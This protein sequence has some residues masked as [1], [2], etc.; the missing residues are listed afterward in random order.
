MLCLEE[1]QIGALMGPHP[2]RKLLSGFF[3]LFIEGHQ[4]SQEYPQWQMQ[5]CTCC[6]AK[7]SGN[8]R[9]MWCLSHRLKHCHFFGSGGGGGGKRRAALHIWLPKE[10]HRQLHQHGVSQRSAERRLLMW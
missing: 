10:W 6:K 4:E 8:T 7:A 5:N 1:N 9:N 2:V 3:I